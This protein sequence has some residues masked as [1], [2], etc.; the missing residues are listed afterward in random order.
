MWN[1]KICLNDPNEAEKEKQ[2]KKEHA[3]NNKLADLSQKTLTEIK[4]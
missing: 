4:C 3:E 1:T 2:V